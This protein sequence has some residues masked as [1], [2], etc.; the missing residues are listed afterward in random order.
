MLE[1]QAVYHWVHTSGPL[2]CGYFGNGGLSNSLPRLTSN[3]D[4]PISVSQVAGITGMSFLCLAIVEVFF[5]SLLFSFYIVKKRARIFPLLVSLSNVED[6]NRW[7]CLQVSG[8]EA[9]L[10]S[11]HKHSPE[12]QAPPELEEMSPVLEPA[13]STAPLAWVSGF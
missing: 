10:G 7:R 8:K 5:S 9:Y 13:E 12:L 2:C 4:P 1:K 11:Q 6:A 3:H